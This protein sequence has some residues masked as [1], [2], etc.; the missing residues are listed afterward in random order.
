M[1][2]ARIAAPARLPTIHPLAVIIINAGAP[3]GI[4]G[5]QQTHGRPEE[6][7]GSGQGR[8]TQPLIGQIEME[9][10][11]INGLVRVRHLRI[12]SL[13]VVGRSLPIL[14]QEVL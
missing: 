12:P 13:G 3:H 8:R 1:V 7:V 10:N 5:L 11:R 14:Q 6:L 2:V 4:A 9:G